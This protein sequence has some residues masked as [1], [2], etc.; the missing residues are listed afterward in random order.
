MTENI[1]GTPTHQS[2]EIQHEDERTATNG[3]PVGGDH[4]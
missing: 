2:Q 1:T 4:H 3:F